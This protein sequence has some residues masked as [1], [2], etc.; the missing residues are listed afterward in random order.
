MRGERVAEYLIVTR[1]EVSGEFPDYVEARIQ[2]ALLLD[3]SGR[4]KEAAAH[5]ERVLQMNPD[6]RQAHYFLAGDLLKSGRV[7][8]AIRHLLETTKVEDNFTPVCMQALAIAYERAGNR[9]RAVYYLRQAR[10]RAVSRGTKD[11]ASQLQR[12]IDRLSAEVGRP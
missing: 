1:P 12:D 2:L 4:S 5:Y 11:L 7:E 9:E 10:Q 6:N 8:E 3:D